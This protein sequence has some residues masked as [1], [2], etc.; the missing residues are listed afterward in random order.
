VTPGIAPASPGSRAEW[1]IAFLVHDA[2]SG[3][4]LLSDLLTR[5]LSGV[6]V[7]PEIAFIRLLRLAG[8]AGRTVRKKG[9]AGRMLSGNLVRNLGSSPEALGDLV[10]AQPDPVPTAALVRAILDE[11]LRRAGAGAPDCVVVKHG[12]HARVWREIVSAFGD[13]ARFIHIYRDPRAVVS[14]KL[15][16]TR[17]YVQDETLAWYGPLLAAWR[18]RSYSA[19]MRR[20]RAAG[21]SVLDV[22]YEQLL[23]EPEAQMRRIAGYLGLTL[24][25]RDEPPATDYRIPEAERAIHPLVQGGR[26]QR[27]RAEA[28]STELP[29]SVVRVIEAVAAGEM[30]ARGYAPSCPMSGLRRASV[31]AAGVPGIAR[32]VVS[33]TWRVLMRRRSPCRPG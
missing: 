26:V 21:A 17:P 4:T 9:L 5:R 7:T 27:D 2:R 18:W 3:S 29:K 20:A 15:R 11:H 12:I 30:R 31:I 25:G 28:W 8:R 22:R 10:A 1:S 23:D 6:Y 13:S 24:R 16:T 32:A 14:S 19:A 33:R